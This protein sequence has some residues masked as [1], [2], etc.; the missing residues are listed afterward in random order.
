MFYSESKI[1]SSPQPLKAKG[2]LTVSIPQIP[3]RKVC[4]VTDCNKL[5]T[6]K[7][8][9]NPH[10]RRMRRT[11]TTDFTVGNLIHGMTKTSEYGAWSHMKQRCYNK[12]HRRYADWGGRGIRVCDRWLHSFENFLQDMGKKPSKLHTLERIDNDG[13]YEP[14]NCRWATYSEQARNRRNGWI[15]RRQK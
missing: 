11:G 5:S 3:L 4:S 10:Y 14:S 9:C 15:K 1:K 13:D 2:E 12:K 6:S 7:G 8:L